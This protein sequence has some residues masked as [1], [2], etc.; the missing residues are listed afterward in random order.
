MINAFESITS[1]FARAAAAAPGIHVLAAEALH[2]GFE[3]GDSMLPT[4]SAA[5]RKLLLANADI[6]ISIL[7]EAGF[8][9]TSGVIAGLDS[10]SSWFHHGL[11]LRAEVLVRRWN[12]VT[13]SPAEGG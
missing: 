12:M 8:E 4:R 13:V 11:K 5:D 10:G 9:Q 6:V 2:R 7:K 1:A 3:Y